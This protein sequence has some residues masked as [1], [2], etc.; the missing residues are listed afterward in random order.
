M[1]SPLTRMVVVSASGPIGLA[2][3]SDEGICIII[4]SLEMNIGV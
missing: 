4:F 1:D 2:D 3:G